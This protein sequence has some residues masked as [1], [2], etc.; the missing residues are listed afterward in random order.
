MMMMMMMKLLLLRSFLLHSFLFASLYRFCPYRRRHRRRLCLI[1]SSGTFVPL[2]DSALFSDDDDNDDQ[3][4]S[5]V[6][7]EVVWITFVDY[8]FMF[9]RGGRSQK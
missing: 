9:V 5:A 7:F 6:L 1:P 3:T 4:T 8:L 2:D